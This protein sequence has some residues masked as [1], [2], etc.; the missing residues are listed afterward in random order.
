MSAG[1]GIRVVLGIGWQTCDTHRDR[2]TS[3]RTRVPVRP[4]TV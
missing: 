2:Q 3:R 1:A 4:G